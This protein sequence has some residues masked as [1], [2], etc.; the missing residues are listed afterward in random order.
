MNNPNNNSVTQSFKH[1]S[2]QGHFHRKALTSGR[3][4]Q[5]AQHFLVVEAASS[6]G[7]LKIF[8]TRLG[9]RDDT[10]ISGQL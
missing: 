2:S 4:R 3:S 1:C 5:C 8:K 6:F 10:A 7:T 9:F